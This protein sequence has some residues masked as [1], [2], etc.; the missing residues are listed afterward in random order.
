MSWRVSYKD[1]VVLFVLWAEG[2]NTNALLC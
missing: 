2:L 1:S